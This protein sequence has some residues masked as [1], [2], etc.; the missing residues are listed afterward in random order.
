MAVD[1][2]VVLLEIGAPESRRLLNRHDLP[3]SLA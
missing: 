3:P 2:E 1:T